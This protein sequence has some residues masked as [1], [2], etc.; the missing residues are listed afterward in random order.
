[1]V[2]GKQILDTIF[3]YLRYNMQ[4]TPVT[5]FVKIMVYF[6]IRHTIVQV[7]NSVIRNIITVYLELIKLLFENSITRIVHLALLLN[8]SLLSRLTQLFLYDCIA[9]SCLK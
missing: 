3:L 1:M 2:M 4:T 6:V 5:T 8:F 7:F 9:L